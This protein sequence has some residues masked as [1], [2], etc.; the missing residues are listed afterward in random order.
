MD[1]ANG[2]DNAIPSIPTADTETGRI[3]SRL[4]PPSHSSDLVTETKLFTREEECTLKTA[5]AFVIIK[6]RAKAKAQ[7]QAR[8]EADAE[9]SG[10]NISNSTSRNDR[11]KNDGFT[12]LSTNTTENENLHGITSLSKSS[13][14]WGDDIS[15]LDHLFS[16]CNSRSS[17]CNYEEG[18]RKPC[19]PR[20]L[21]CTEGRSHIDHMFRAAKA[22][23]ETLLITHRN[24]QRHRDQSQVETRVTST[25]MV[26][27]S[28]ALVGAT[29]HLARQLQLLLVANQTINST[30]DKSTPTKPS[31]ITQSLLAKR[32]GRDKRTSK[33]RYRR[34]STSSKSAADSTSTPSSSSRTDVATS[35]AN[36]AAN[37]SAN[38]KTDARNGDE[39]NRNSTAIE[40][41]V[42]VQEWIRSTLLQLGDNKQHTAT[43][44]TPN[45]DSKSTT[46][47]LSCRNATVYDVL[48]PFHV[49]TVMVP[50]I[51]RIC[52]PLI[53]HIFQVVAKLVKGLYNDKITVVD[54]AATIVSDDN[55][56]RELSVTTCDDNARQILDH[57]ATSAL[58]LLEICWTTKV[59]GS[60]SM[61][62]ED[63][64]S[65]LLLSLQEILGDLLIPLS[66]SELA[67]EH[68]RLAI[69]ASR[70][71]TFRKRKPKKQQRSHDNA[72]RS[73]KY[74]KLP[75]VRQQRRL[76]LPHS[77]QFESEAS[78]QGQTLRKARDDPSGSTGISATPKKDDVKNDNFPA[79]KSGA[80][81]RFTP[82]LRPNTVGGGCLL[83]PE[84]KILLR[85]AVYRLILM[86][87][88]T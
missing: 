18:F 49:Y 6:A 48:A 67:G 15:I 72:P 88:K 5:L 58:T 32:K 35:V 42:D 36:P 68:Y 87:N 84:A 19:P 26:A 4:T 34:P 56:E 50:Q 2:N 63:H 60:H 10:T 74:Q 37:H 8:A 76:V 47:I 30:D 22:L 77:S 13:S 70:K 64:R 85:I 17:L 11:H 65:F 29:G 14:A 33:V 43:A 3:E 52:P 78:S 25:T 86:E 41:I 46:T 23:A 80:S 59:I 16:H 66:R 27:T 44:D 7:A 20:Y 71:Q 83:D 61:C 40:S 79:P 21:E 24:Q 28:K 57:L 1:G 38:G 82:P 81:L 45:L 73:S 62:G 69:A 54:E 31:S 55:G 39:T 75:R 9:A 53:G 12:E 51:S